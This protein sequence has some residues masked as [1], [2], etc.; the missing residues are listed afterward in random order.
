[1]SLRQEQ[2]QNTFDKEQLY[3]SY[4]PPQTHLTDQRGMLSHQAQEDNEYARLGR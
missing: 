2:R 4:S 1:M 3:Q